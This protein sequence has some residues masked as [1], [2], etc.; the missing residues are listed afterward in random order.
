MWWGGG[1]AIGLVP[2]SLFAAS[3]HPHP[4]AAPLQPC[5]A[6][7]TEGRRDT[8]PWGRGDGM[9]TLTSNR[10]TTATNG[11]TDPQPQWDGGAE[12]ERRDEGAV[13]PFLPGAVPVA[14]LTQERSGCGVTP[15]RCCSIKATTP[16][17]KATSRCSGRAVLEWC[18]P[19]EGYF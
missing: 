1:G 19:E 3:P 8:Q 2:K 4:A 15:S 18:C 17:K 7:G 13:N 16:S 12:E 5:A 14:F 10:D 9:G 11:P 6:D